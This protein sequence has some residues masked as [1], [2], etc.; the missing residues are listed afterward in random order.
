MPPFLGMKQQV[1]FLAQLRNARALVLRDAESFHEASTVLEHIGQVLAKQVRNGLGGYQS[2]ILSLASESE[3]CDREEAARLFKT[4]REARNM[5][6]HEGAWARHL[7]SRLVDLF[8]ILEEAIMTK[9][10]R[11]EDLMVRDPVITE[12]W[13]LVAHARKTML[14]NSFSFLPIFIGGESGGHWKLLTDVVVMR[15]LRS[16]ESKA[17]SQRRLSAPIGDA[18]AKGELEATGAVCCPPHTLLSELLLKI[19]HLPV[20]VTQEFDGKP[21]LLGIIAPFDLL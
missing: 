6:V 7:S 14:A 2:E 12:T 13:C 4:V 11:V 21:R 5:A 20:L 18:I 15:F 19:N 8:L 16:A 1:E 10:D 3:R 9:M 17:D